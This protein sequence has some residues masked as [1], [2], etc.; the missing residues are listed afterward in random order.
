[1]RRDFC[2]AACNLT[3]LDKQRF[4]GAVMRR[5]AHGVLLSEVGLRVMD[6]VSYAFMAHLVF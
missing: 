4:R 3:V 2:R 1:M 6:A 5:M